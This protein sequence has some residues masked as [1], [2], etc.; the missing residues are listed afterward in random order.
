MWHNIIDDAAS[1]LIT[2]VVSNSCQKA[3]WP[4]LT[5]TQET[6]WHWWD[7]YLSIKCSAA[8]LDM[9]DI[10]SLQVF[11]CF[12]FPT[13]QQITNWTAVSPKKTRQ[14]YVSSKT[15]FQSS[16]NTRATWVSSGKNHR[17]CQTPWISY[18]LFSLQDF[19]CRS[20]EDWINKC[21]STWQSYWSA[22]CMKVGIWQFIGSKATE[23]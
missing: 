5:A 22:K 20:K 18:S 14:V 2:K 1:H 9:A 11:P 7:G 12:T 13:C 10:F 6:Q 8:A 3:S 16:P 23:C 17:Y 19:K 15:C 4:W 21:I